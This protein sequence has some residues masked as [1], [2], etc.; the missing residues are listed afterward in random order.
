M[1]VE[2]AIRERRTLKA[3]AE[4]FVPSAWE[5]DFIRRGTRDAG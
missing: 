1:Q 2:E 3:F 4:A 5:E